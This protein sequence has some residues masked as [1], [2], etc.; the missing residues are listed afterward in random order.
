MSQQRRQKEPERPILL[1]A[2]LWGFAVAQPLYDILGKHVEFFIARR[3]LSLSVIVLALCVSFLI[4]G[5]I[6]VLM[7]ASRRLGVFA[8]HVLSM[9]L[10][11]LLGSMAAL[12]ILRRTLNA[13]GVFA[14]SL[15]IAIGVLFLAMY[16]RLAPVR[17]LVLVLSPSIVIFPAVFLFLTPVSKVVFPK[18]V[19]DELIVEVPDTPVVFVLFDMFS[20]ATLMDESGSIDAIRYPNFGRFAARAHWFRQAETIDIATAR[21][22]PA[23]L[24]GHRVV[25]GTFPVYEDHPSNLFTLFGSKR[26][27]WVFESTSKLCPEALCSEEPK[28]LTA[29]IHGLLADS[30][31]IYLHVLLPESMTGSLAPVDSQWYGFGGQVVEV[32]HEDSDSGI[33][34]EKK[35][36]LQ[37]LVKATLREDRLA[38]LE[39][40]LTSIQV[41][42]LSYLHLNLPH[43]P[44]VYLSSGRTYIPQVAGYN[45][46]GLKRNLGQTTEGPTKFW[47]DDEYLVRLAFQRMAL[48]AGLAD[49]VLGLILDRLAELEILDEALIVV[50]ADHGESYVP[51]EPV[52][53]MED[54]G[55]AFVPLLIRE[56]GQTVGTVDDRPATILDI[57]PTI[58]SILEFTIPW[59]VEGNVLIGEEAGESVSNSASLDARLA[60]AWQQKL[61]WVGAGDPLQIHRVGPHPEIVGVDVSRNSESA[62]ERSLEVGEVRQD[63]RVRLDLAELLKNVDLDSEFLPAFVTGRIRLPKG[64]RAPV[65]LAIEINGVIRATCRAHEKISSSKWRFAALIPE[66][67]FRPGE[68]SWQVFYI[69]ETQGGSKRLIPTVSLEADRRSPR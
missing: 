28:T 14:L 41:R 34:S 61:D 45:K 66:S 36:Q 56:P 26:S 38:K 42:G 65:E 33:Q 9:S 69:E 51:G 68:N 57:L 52:R 18:A 32:Q 8:A 5:T 53:A 12:P 20:T 19:A 37:E 6:A 2:V 46:L 11:I 63:I 21:A 43:G 16:R 48:Q 1:V 13:D 4:P 17:Y 23:L 29:D 55:T 35:A 40:F 50:A 25:P 49:R 59:R 31:V 7:L 22:V 27:V 44:F 39:R 67:A 54:G 60:D 10:A 64:T 30:L 58:A 47:G 62:G 15:A 24:T 3:T